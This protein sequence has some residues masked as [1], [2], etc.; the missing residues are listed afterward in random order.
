MNNLRILGTREQRLKRSRAVYDQFVVC[1][2]VLESFLKYA[3]WEKKLDNLVEV[4]DVYTRALVVLGD[5][6]NQPKYFIDF[7]EMEI[8]AGEVKFLNGNNLS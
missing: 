2:P 1:H 5:E 8:D 4:R 6:V 3:S 7:S